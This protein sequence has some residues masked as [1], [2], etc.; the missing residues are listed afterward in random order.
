M[1]DSRDYRNS[2]QLGTKTDK[3]LHGKIAI[4][5]VLFLFL[6]YSV[7]IFVQ[8]LSIAIRHKA[9]QRASSFNE[10]QNVK[11]SYCKIRSTYLHYRHFQMYCIYFNVEKDWVCNLNSRAP[12][13]LNRLLLLLFTNGVWRLTCW[14]WVSWILR[15]N[16]KSGR[17]NWN[18][19]IQWPS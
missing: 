1:E 13:T 14:S 10:S 4:D 17:V 15:G 19:V 8:L 3:L 11:Y 6:K 16:V 12:L 18:S 5:A 2:S 9:N 7:Y